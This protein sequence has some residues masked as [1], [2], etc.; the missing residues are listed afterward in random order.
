MDIMIYIIKSDMLSKIQGTQ[1]SK[2][3]VVGYIQKEIA[4]ICTNKFDVGKS[5]NKSIYHMH[6]SLRLGL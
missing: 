1:K 5:N 2:C 6:Y 3:C 4:M